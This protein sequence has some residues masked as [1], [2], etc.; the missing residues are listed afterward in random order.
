M[1]VLF[2]PSDAAGP[3]ADEIVNAV[4]GQ[5]PN[6]TLVSRVGHPSYA[7]RVLEAISSPAARS[8]LARNPKSR[9]GLMEEYVVLTYPT[10]ELAAVAMTLLR[11][12]SNVL[13]AGPNHTYTLSG[14]VPNDRYFVQDPLHP[15]AENYQW[16]MQLLNMPG[17]WAMERGTAYVGA[18]D[19]GID[20]GGS[21]PCT[22]SGL[23]PDLMQNMRLHFSKNFSYAGGTSFNVDDHIDQCSANPCSEVHGTHVAGIIAATPEYGSYT[24]GQTNTGVAG[25]C[26]TCSFAMLR[27][28]GNDV[29]LGGAITYAAD[30]GLQALNMSFGDAYESNYT[31]CSDADFEWRCQ[32]LGHAADLELVSVGAAGN[33]Y[34]SRIQFPARVS[35]V[36]AVGGLEAPGVFFRDGYGLS[37]LPY[38]AYPCVPGNYG[39]ECG[40]N[41]GTQD[42][43]TPQIV[44]PAMDGLDCVP[45]TRPQCK[46]TLR[47]FVRSGRRFSEWIRGLYWDI[48]VCARDNRSSGFDSIRKSPVDTCPSEIHRT[49]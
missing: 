35:T 28:E 16:G 12:D 23:H 44:A 39:P 36:I 48:D 32:A 21:N 22:Q 6:P 45:F 9:R 14:T 24:N 2:N 31:S 29:T 30:H 3:H 46:C 33:L 8:E 4:R 43:G 27:S 38:P 26:W 42:D 41:Y 1:I 47:R 11:R 19:A 25:A 15:A 40:S 37:Y 49:S 34:D 18:I 17:A 20:C 13:F 5:V 10:E 7:S